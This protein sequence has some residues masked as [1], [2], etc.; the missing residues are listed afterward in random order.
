MFYTFHLQS[1][2][3]Q[4][5]NINFNVKRSSLIFY[6]LHLQYSV[7]QEKHKFQSEISSAMFYSFHLQSSVAQKKTNKKNINFTVKR[8]SLMFYNLHLQSSVTE[9]KHK[10]QI[11]KIIYNV[12]HFSSTIFSRSEKK[13][14]QQHKFQ[15]KKIIFNVLQSSSTIF[16]SWGFQERICLSRPYPFKFFKSC[17]PQIL[18]GPFLNT[19]PQIIIYQ[20]FNKSST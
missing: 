19:L 7:T 17:L 18:L 4:K 6:N 16:S 3:A 11:K 20:E 15:C 12:L 14:Q 13:Q 2:V 10:F 9:E 8:S 1:S 5:N